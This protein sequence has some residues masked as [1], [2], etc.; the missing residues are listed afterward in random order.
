MPEACAGVLGAKANA[1]ATRKLLITVRYSI[2][3]KGSQSR[4][5]AQILFL[6]ENRKD[7]TNEHLFP[8]DV[9]AGTLAIFYV[10]IFIVAAFLAVCWIAFP[11]SSFP[12]STS[13]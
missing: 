9:S 1:A 2:V 6:C 4:K 10:V 11:S 7:R 8:P 3:N 12:N 5:V 13:Y